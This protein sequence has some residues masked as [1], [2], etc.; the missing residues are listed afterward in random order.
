[1]TIHDAIS[2]LA[3]VISGQI[4]Y[5]DDVIEPTPTTEAGRAV[6]SVLTDLRAVMDRITYAQTSGLWFDNL[7]RPTTEARLLADARQRFVLLRMALGRHC[8]SDG[9]NSG[10]RAEL[11]QALDA[12]EAALG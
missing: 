7:N 3:Q 2:Q 6:A 4:N 10:D 5:R 8:W 1:M 11:A 9:L 12:V